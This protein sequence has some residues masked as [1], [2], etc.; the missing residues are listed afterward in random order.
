MDAFTQ[1]FWNKVLLCKRFLYYLY[2]IYCRLAHVHLT[3]ILY[4]TLTNMSTIVQ[5]QYKETD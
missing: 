4:D 2:L 3:D 1:K 5:F